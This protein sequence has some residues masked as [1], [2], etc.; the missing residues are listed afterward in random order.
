MGLQHPAAE[1]LRD[2]TSV[3]SL[4][5]FANR[6]F[7]VCQENFNVAANLMDSLGGKAWSTFGDV[8]DKLNKLRMVQDQV[9]SCVKIEGVEG[10]ATIFKSLSMLDGRI[11]DRIRRTDPRDKGKG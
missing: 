1:M 4:A 5:N 11:G 6:C 8:F 10:V 7:G 9:G 3:V 2:Q